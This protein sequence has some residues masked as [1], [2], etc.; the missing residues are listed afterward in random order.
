V[1]PEVAV[2]YL[3]HLAVV[4]PVQTFVAVVVFLAVDGDGVVAGISDSQLDGVLFGAREAVARPLN[5][6]SNNFFAADVFKFDDGVHLLF[7]C[8]V[9]PCWGSSVQRLSC[10]PHQIH[11]LLTALESGITERSFCCFLPPLVSV[12]GCLFAAM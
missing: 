2:E 4:R 3:L 1:S 8:M 9:S 5:T 10:R 7:V 12:D 6:A 11:S